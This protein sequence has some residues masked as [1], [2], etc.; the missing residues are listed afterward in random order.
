[1][2]KPGVFGEVLEAADR[3]SPEDKEVL[4]EVLQRRLLDERREEIAREIA[5]ANR[6]FQAGQCQPATPEELMKEILG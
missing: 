2:E 1:M 5:A 6:E 4:I 3:L